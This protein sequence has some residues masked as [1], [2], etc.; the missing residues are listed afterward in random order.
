MAA[1]N[2]TMRLHQA[3]R[4]TGVREAMTDVATDE[5]AEEAAG[6][7]GEYGCSRQ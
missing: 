4:P 7:I 1:M 2:P 5:V 3:L 6:A